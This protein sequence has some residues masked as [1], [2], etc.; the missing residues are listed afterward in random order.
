[1]NNLPNNLF[2]LLPL[3]ENENGSQSMWPPNP[4]PG[5][6]Y[7]SRT[8]I[9]EGLHTV[10]PADLAV[11]PV[12]PGPVKA[13]LIPQTHAAT[14]GTKS[15]SSK[16]LSHVSTPALTPQ[17]ADGGC[18]TPETSVDGE[19]D[20]R[21]ALVEF[22][23]TKPNPQKFKMI[24][25]APPKPNA[26]ETNEGFLTPQVE[27]PSLMPSRHDIALPE[28]VLQDVFIPSRVLPGIHAA[29]LGQ[30]THGPGPADL[31]WV[32]HHSVSYD[33]T[34]FDDINA[35]FNLGEDEHFE[36]QIFMSTYPP[37][38]DNAVNT[39]DLR[40]EPPN[41]SNSHF[42]SDDL[43]LPTYQMETGLTSVDHTSSRP[44]TGVLG[45]SDVPVQDMPLQ[46][47]EPG[48]SSTN[49][50]E[51]SRRDTS[52]DLELLGLRAQGISYREIK[53][54]Y[55]FTEAEST[56]RGRYRTLT[57]SKDKRVRKPVW[58][59]KDVSLWNAVSAAMLTR[60]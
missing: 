14:N 45:N 11:H 30:A 50:G 43:F 4:L 51:G 21:N 16:S 60:V 44:Y 19:A 10:S 47:V 32:G 12:A 8:Q 29:A 55:G 17:T 5:P 7:H 23:P 20:H 36:N 27:L 1:M 18:S 38:T 52:R 40:P 22:R 28:K 9:P 34:R 26:T 58:K 48:V 59:D 33:Q 25:P 24:L 46:S 15:E 37:L 31:D 53:Q 54:K 57:K 2:D 41:S 39:Y 3:S 6:S 49:C 42:H 56:L 35:F 13:P